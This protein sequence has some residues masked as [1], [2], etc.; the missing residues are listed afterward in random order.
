[1]CIL[2]GEGVLTGLCNQG[3]RSLARTLSFTTKERCWS[4]NHGFFF[5]H[6]LGS[7]PEEGWR[8][9]TTGGEDDFRLVQPL[10]DATLVIESSE[11]DN[12]ASKRLSIQQRREIFQDLVEIQDSLIPVNVRKSY[13]IVT[14]KYEITEAQLRQI[15][16]EGIE[17]QWPPLNEVLP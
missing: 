14:E 8:R 12:M 1:L 3:N 11:G 5:P 7:G 17:K 4:C 9:Q 15:E 16:N 13:E 6:S 2:N 10:E